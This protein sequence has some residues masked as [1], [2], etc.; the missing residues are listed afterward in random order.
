MKT[1]IRLKFNSKGTKPSE[2]FRI[3]KEHNFVPAIGEYDFVYDWGEGRDVG[4]SEIIS[5]LDSIHG[6]LG[7]MD[8]VYEV[9]TSDPMYHIKEVTPT[10]P[11]PE[12]AVTKPSTQAPEPPAPPD[13]EAPEPKCPT[14]NREAAYIKRYDRWY[15]H[16]C[17]K[18]I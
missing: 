4:V 10:T 3:L 6:A 8:V 9:T 14:C 17:K 2:V 13:D 16:T 11:S 5:T 1:Y 15:C 12:P 18:Y 7:G